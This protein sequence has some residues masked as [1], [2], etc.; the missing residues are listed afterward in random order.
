MEPDPKELQYL[1]QRFLQDTA[2]PDEIREFWKLFYEAKEDG[3]M[4]QDLWQLWDKVKPEEEFGNR[5][6]A[7]TF[8]DIK[9][10][11]EAWEKKRP[12]KTIRFLRTWRA[13]AAAAIILLL[14]TGAYLLFFHKEPTEIAQTEI[15]PSTKMDIRPGGNKAMLI[16]ANGRQ[17]TLDSTH[18]GQLANQ[19]NSKIVKVKSGLLTYTK[20]DI[21][22]GVLAGA[23]PYNTLV[24]PKGGEY[25]LI[26]SDGTKVWL[27]AASSIHY[28]VT[29]TGGQR[30][31]EITGEAYFEVAKNDN[32]PFIVKDG[33]TE[34]QVLGTHFDVNGYKDEPTIKVTL[35]EGEVR[36]VQLITRRSQLLKPGEQ[37]Q[38]NLQ[39]QIQLIK[40]ADTEAA[41]AWK[42]GYF[43][44]D[45]EDLGTIM[46]QVSRWYDVEVKYS[47][48]KLENQLFSGTVSRFKNVSE[49]L[50]MLSLTGAAHFK[51]D[52]EEIIVTK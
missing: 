14:G 48:V 33:N 15:Q 43:Q 31:V 18:M 34:V 23:S 39:G 51:I 17:I 42:N 3:H 4:K 32:M 27:N 24:T 25:Q 44:F 37:A 9:R 46:R 13:A 19:G 8:E 28:P 6:R 36:T 10:R 1:F 29:F 26:L 30:L 2:T 5:E 49:L 47:D 21:S 38:M 22:T 35:L 7:H 16:L 11:S 40:N 52:G 45:R 12:S 20:T 41:V 50:K